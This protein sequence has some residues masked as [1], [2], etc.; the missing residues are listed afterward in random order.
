MTT[1]QLQIRQLS[2]VPKA[3]EGACRTKRSSCSMF[4]GTLRNPVA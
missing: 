3:E 1:L 4:T 2:C